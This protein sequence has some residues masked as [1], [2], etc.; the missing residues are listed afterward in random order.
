[1]RSPVLNSYTVKYIIPPGM[2]THTN[3]KDLFK[4]E[5]GMEAEYERTGDV[6]EEIRKG[7]CRG[8]K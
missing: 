3:Y 7:D 6:A 8:L 5:K 1:M 2:R 4:V